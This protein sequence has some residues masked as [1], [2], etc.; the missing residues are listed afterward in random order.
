MNLFFCSANLQAIVVEQ[1][2][3]REKGDDSRATT[4]FLLQTARARFLSR[5]RP[6][7]SDF[8]FINHAPVDDFQTE[9]KSHS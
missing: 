3:Q 4:S 6:R 1:P 5:R 7:Q 2:A 8:V 9:E